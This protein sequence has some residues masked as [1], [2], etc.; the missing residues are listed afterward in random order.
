[1]LLNIAIILQILPI[2]WKKLE[3]NLKTFLFL[4][5]EGGTVQVLNMN[6]SCFGRGSSRN[7]TQHVHGREGGPKSPFLTWRN[8]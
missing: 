2:T 3:K 8:L 1:M 7:M 5:F 6:K 4:H